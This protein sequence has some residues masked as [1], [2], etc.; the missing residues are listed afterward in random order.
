MIL[1]PW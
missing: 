1:Q